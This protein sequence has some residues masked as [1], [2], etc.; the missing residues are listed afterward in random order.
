MKRAFGLIAATAAALA[1]TACGSSSGGASPQ[2]SGNVTMFTG[3]PNAAASSSFESAAAARSSAEASLSSAMAA[4]SASAASQPCAT[5]ACIVQDAEQ[6]L[7]GGIAEDNAVATKAKCYK[8][9]VKHHAAA[10]TWSVECTVDYTDGTSATGIAN[11]LLDQDKITFE[12]T[13]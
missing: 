11:L 8:S 1:L 2:P 10:K 13:G 7:P 4:A 12:P 5:R 3:S 6:S 9:T